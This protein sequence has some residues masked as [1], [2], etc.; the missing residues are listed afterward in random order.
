MLSFGD[1]LSALGK[2]LSALGNVQTDLSVP[3]CFLI[4]TRF[5]KLFS[6][7]VHSDRARAPRLQSKT[8]LVSTARCFPPELAIQRSRPTAAVY[9]FARE[10]GTSE[11]ELENSAEAQKMNF[12]EFR[13]HD[14]ITNVLKTDHMLLIAVAIFCRA[15]RCVAHLATW[16]AC[17]D[18]D[19]VHRHR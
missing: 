16:S 2:L 17:A 9:N 6:C 10:L 15:I 14:Q 4:I 1:M 3:L 19:F 12:T 18:D 7:S 8:V 11:K 13:H 5:P